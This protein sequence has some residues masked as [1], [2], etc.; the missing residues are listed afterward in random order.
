M[1]SLS[2]RPIPEASDP[3]AG[4]Q[5]PP[6]PPAPKRDWRR[7]LEMFG[8][9]REDP[10]RSAEL[11]MEMVD[12]LGGYYDGDKPFQSFAAHPEGRR[13]LQERPCLPS[14]VADRA[15]L[16]RLPE[17]SFGRAYLDLCERAGISADAL[18]EMTENT[19]QAPSYDPL[20][21]WFN[22]RTTAAH[23]L[24]HVLTGYGTDAIGENA[25]LLFTRGQG[26]A[27][28][29]L[30]TMTTLMLLG[31]SFRRFI[32]D[33]Y[34]RGRRVPSLLTAPYEQLLPM[35]LTQVRDQLGLGQPEDAHPDGIL[36]E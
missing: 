26:L 9:I 28:P 27:G 34:W 5:I 21:S 2:H 8:R 16:A 1:T 25:L 3:A 14:A 18:I 31:Q 24:Q 13:M 11:G 17:D 23:D 4:L 6:P 30:R 22:D 10:S 36:Q 7:A 12:A 35:P 32:W 15:A 29:G 33:A 19:S 20:R